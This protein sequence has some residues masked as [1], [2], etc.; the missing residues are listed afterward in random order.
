MWRQATRLAAHG[1]LR[2]LKTFGG[3][4]V[5]TSTC[6]H[7]SCVYL[8]RAG[9]VVASHLP[10]M[11]KARGSIPSVST[12]LLEFGCVVAYLLADLIFFPRFMCRQIVTPAGLEP[13]TPGCVGRCLIHL[14]TG[15]SVSVLMQNQ[16]SMKWKCALT[17]VSDA[18]SD[19]L[20]LET[21]CTNTFTSLLCRA[22]NKIS[23]DSPPTQ[24]RPTRYHI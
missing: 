20:N 8:S 16:P 10:R 5:V 17:V 6:L 12:Q 11:Q 1:I 18:S 19:Q 24:S 3:E 15:P 2:P 14:A 7:V 4:T 23:I 9:G 13:A 21:A 22:K